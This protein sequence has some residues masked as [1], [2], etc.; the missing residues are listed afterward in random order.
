LADFATNTG[1]PSLHRSFG[2]HLTQK[3]SQFLW[4][5]MP[6]SSFINLF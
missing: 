1:T 5:D 3:V 2:R 4:C 6:W